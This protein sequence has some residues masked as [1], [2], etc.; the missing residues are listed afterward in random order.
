MPSFAV[1]L[2]AAGKSQRFRDPHYKKPFIDLAGRAVWMHAAEKF[3]GRNDCRQVLVVIAPEDREDFYRRF[4]ANVAILG[5]E[6]CEGGKERADSVA[7][8]LTRVKDDIDFIAVHDAARPCIATLWIDRVFA[9][10][11]Q[12][13]AAILA[14]PV[15]DT[16]K[17]IDANHCVAETITREGLWQIQTPQVFRRELLLKAYANR[18]KEPVTDDALLVE[19]L[20]H[21][22]H[23][24]TGSSLNV[25]I[26]TKDDLRLAT[27]ALQVLP[28]PKLDGPMHPFADN[29]LW[30]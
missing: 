22:V 9:A 26:T 28:K 24:V 11:V 13:D 20:G 21:P 8:A 17:R 6:I 25:K 30:R 2:P 12:H 4:G 27:Q 3:L 7:A 16:L 23:V 14:I 10:A 5:V 15:S 19:R 1:I 18:G 29:D